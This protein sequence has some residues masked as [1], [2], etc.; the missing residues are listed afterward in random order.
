[1]EDE[2][3]FYSDSKEYGW[4]S[5][6]YPSE[7][8]IDGV[9]YPTNEHYY[10]SQKI[11][12]ISLR[13]WIIKSPKP[14]YI[15]RLTR[16]LKTYEVV[17][18]WDNI[19]V[20]VMLKGLRAKFYQNSLLKKKLLNTGNKI[21]HEDSKSDFFWGMKGQDMLGKLLMKVRSELQKDE[22]EE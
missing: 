12:D 4:L 6:F 5:N 11:K 2:I 14:S 10:Q 13:L 18:N 22:K 19:K 9:S 7:Q 3:K 21:L 1:M 8:K 17:H 20:S 16:L 15:F